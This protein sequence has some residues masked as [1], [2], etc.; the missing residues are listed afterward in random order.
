M[1]TEENKN[2]LS[3]EELDYRLEQGTTILVNEKG[4]D[5][6]FD[7]VIEAYSEKDVAKDTYAKIYRCTVTETHAGEY[8]PGDTVHVD[9]RD[10]VRVFDDA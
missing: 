5:N 4:S 6:Q 2:E 3:L 9:N 8:E 7:A 10:V 1:T